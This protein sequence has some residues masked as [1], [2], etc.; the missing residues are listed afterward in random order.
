MEYSTRIQYYISTT[1]S[2]PSNKI[3]SFFLVTEINTIGF[4]GSIA[5]GLVGGALCGIDGVWIPQPD[6]MPKMPKLQVGGRRRYT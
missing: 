4:A 5:S 6:A 1:N 3:C 2:F